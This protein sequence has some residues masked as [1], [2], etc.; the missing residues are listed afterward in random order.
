VKFVWD[1]KTVIWELYNVFEVFGLSM[2]HP[3]SRDRAQDSSVH[4]RGPAI[5]DPP[6]SRGVNPHFAIPYDPHSPGVSPGYDSLLDIDF[7]NSH[8]F[9]AGGAPEN[10]STW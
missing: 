9:H 1:K 2:S 4:S 6:Q 10:A 5:E 8:Q 3:V 7:V